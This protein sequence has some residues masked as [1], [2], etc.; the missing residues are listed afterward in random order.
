MTLQ[1]GIF[2]LFHQRLICSLPRVTQRR[3]NVSTPGIPTPLLT[4]AY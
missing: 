2:S 3:A 1:L 4:M